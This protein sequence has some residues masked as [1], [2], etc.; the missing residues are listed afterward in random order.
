M[1]G[2]D[3]EKIRNFDIDWAINQSKQLVWKTFVL[4][5]YF[6]FKIIREDKWQNEI[7]IAQLNPVVGAIGKI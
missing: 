1:L 4:P 2:L 3:G 5:V 6:L 7:T